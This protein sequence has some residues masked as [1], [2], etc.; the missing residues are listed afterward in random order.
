M[1]FRRGQGLN[2]AVQDAFAVCK[3]IQRFWKDGAYT[4]EDRCQAIR[5]Y[6][7]EMISRTGEEVRLSEASSYAIHDW[8]K[9]M[10]SPLVQR[11]LTVER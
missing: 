4:V 1:T 9:V 5:E 11:G 3:A 2:H 6:E 7:T 8:A 10:Q